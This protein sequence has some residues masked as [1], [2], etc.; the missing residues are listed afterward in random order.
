MFADEAKS[1]FEKLLTNQG[2]RLN[3]DMPL[4]Q[5]GTYDWDKGGRFPFDCVRRFILADGEDDSLLPL[6]LEFQLPTGRRITGAG[7]RQP[8]VQIA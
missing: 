2:I 3:I 8:L 6:W 1:E 5:W 7:K 4:V